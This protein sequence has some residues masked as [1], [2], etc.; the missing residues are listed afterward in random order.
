MGVHNAQKTFHSK[1]F[2]NLQLRTFYILHHRIFKYL[3]STE[4]PNHHLISIL[5][6]HQFSF[7]QIKLHFLVRE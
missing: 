1:A 2:C 5:K 4:H 3:H 6:I 7:E